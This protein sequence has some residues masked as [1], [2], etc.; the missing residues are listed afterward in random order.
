M[1][2]ITKQFIL[3]VVPKVEQKL[4]VIYPWEQT[5]LFN[6]CQ[7][8]YE[9]AAQTGYHGTFNEFKQYFGS[10]LENGDIVID[11]DVYNGQYTV[12]P[13]P[14]VEQILRT[15]NKILKHD[16]VIQ[17]I[18]YAEVSNLAGGKTVTIG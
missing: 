13:L 1:E 3:P 6:L 12:T 8:L 4:P 11:Y 7:Q 17:P 9:L 10:Y 16:I 5:N 2:A 15:D 18:P 14:N